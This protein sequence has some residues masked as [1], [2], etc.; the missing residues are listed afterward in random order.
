MQERYIFTLILIHRSSS[1]LLASPNCTCLDTYLIFRPMQCAHLRISCCW[2][3]HRGWPSSHWNNIVEPINQFFF[4]NRICWAILYHIIWLVCIY[5]SYKNHPTALNHI[6]TTTSP[7]A[8]SPAWDPATPMQENNEF[9]SIFKC[10]Y[11]AYTSSRVAASYSD[12]RSLMQ[13]ISWG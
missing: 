9:S 6:R 12:V 2:A 7:V 10:S 8:T 11:A 3:G 13:D 1:W 4:Y 5:N